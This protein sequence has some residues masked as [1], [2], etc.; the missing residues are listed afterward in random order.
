MKKLSLTAVAF[1]MLSLF[2]T[3]YLHA[4]DLEAFE[5]NVT[6]FTLDNGLSFVVMQRDVAPVVSFVTYIDVGAA[7]EPVGQTGIAHIFEHMAFKGSGEIGTT[8]FE[9]EKKV[10]EQMDIAY[11]EWL[12]EKNRS[13]PDDEKLEEKWEEF[14]RLQEESHE[15]VVNNEFTQYIEREGASGLNAF[16]SADA[17]AYFYSLP[18][19]KAELWF[20]LEADRFKQPVMREFYTEKDVIHEERRSRTDSN[21]MG[22]LLEEFISIAYSAHPYK[23]PVIGWP[24]DIQ[25]T[26]IKDALEFYEDYYVPSNITIGITGDIDPDEMKRLAELY[27]GDM[28]AGEPAPQLLIKEP[29]QRGERRFV[30]ED[31][32][33]PL[34][35]MGFHGVAENHPDAKALDLLGSILADGRTS[36]LYRRMV[37]DDQ[38]ALQLQALSGYP[39]SKYQS[40]FVT[41]V[42]PNQGV[43][44]ADVE[45][46]VLE[47]IEKVKN[48]EITQN[49]LDR[50]RTNARASL[51]RGLASNSGLALRL[52]EA[53]GKHDDWRTIFTDLDELN[54]VTLDDL[55]RVAATYLIEK[56]RTVGTIQNEQDEEVA[57]N[58]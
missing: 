26:T 3:K 46:T 54:E 25:N 50:V 42:V 2:N 18:Q 21:P 10:I 53:S 52:A 58:Q 40:M 33:Q 1:L 30:I 55:Q 6:E 27:F 31:S 51:V 17:T 28:P 41:F 13:N 14:E 45:E 44:V 20:S 32:S 7:N 9:E 24:S 57:G 15:Y 4:Q 19:N 29:E 47:E 22:R 49:E 8:N 12:R 34:F 48:G 43:D 23:N 35:L 56:N 37:V 38:S 36:R 16:T 5:K 11:R 39:G